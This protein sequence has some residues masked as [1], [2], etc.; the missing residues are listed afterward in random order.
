MVA[1][2]SGPPPQAGRNTP[3]SQRQPAGTPV[4]RPL[5]SKPQTH[6]RPA[7]Q[8]TMPAVSGRQAGGA[9]AAAEAGARAKPRASRSRERTGPVMRKA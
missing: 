7:M 8:A 6:I 3:Q 4:M 2:V 1:G 9:C 5:R